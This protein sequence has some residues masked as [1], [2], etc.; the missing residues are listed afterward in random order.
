MA[1]TTTLPELAEIDA[2]PQI[3]SIY[4]ELRELSGTPMV[5]LIW[6]HLATIPDALPKVWSTLQ[7]LLV[8]GVVQEAAWRSASEG[9]QAPAARL[10]QAK[11]SG[12]G[13]DAEVQGSFVRVLDAY[14][15]ANPINFLAVR[16]LLRAIHGEGEGQALP[17]RNWAPPPAIGQLPPMAPVA[18]FSDAQRKLVN[19]LSSS[20][21]VDRSLVVPSLYRHLVGWPGLISLVHAELSPRFEAGEVGRLVAAAAGAMEAEAARLT[22]YM[23]VLT[24]LARQDQIVDALTSFS[25]LIPEMIVVGLLLRRGLEDE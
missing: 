21:R 18:C 9:V 14:N 17:K 6:R 23:P 11:L 7:P 19:S 2:P 10:R 12:A 22:V 8:G 1:D 25:L 15:R 16:L 13:L 4:R 20:T 24:D 3:A 5:A